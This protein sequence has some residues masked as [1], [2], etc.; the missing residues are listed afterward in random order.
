M[1]FF[2][3]DTY[4]ETLGLFSHEFFHLWNVKRMRPAALVPFD[5]GREQYTRL[6]WWF[7]GAT[8]YYEG[9]ALAR[10]GILDGKQYPAQPRPRRSRSSSARR[11][12]AR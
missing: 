4:E 9:L 6:L 11:A 3:R 1:R 2:P 10:A 7:E 5:Y 12:R 8:T